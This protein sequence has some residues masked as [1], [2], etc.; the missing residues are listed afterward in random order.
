MD[1]V[2]IRMTRQ[3]AKKLLAFLDGI[4]DIEEQADGDVRQLNNDDIC[5]LWADL[6]DALKAKQDPNDER[7][8]QDA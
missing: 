5:V 2:S 6:T 3:L 4:N 1:Q 8:N 7:A